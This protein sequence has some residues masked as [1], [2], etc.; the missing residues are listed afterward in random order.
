MS[1][2]IIPL[3]VVRVREPRTNLLMKNRYAILDGPQ[4]NSW[5]PVIST[6]Y[7]N[8][9]VQFSAPPPS[10]NIIVDRQV[11]V[12]MQLDIDIKG[13]DQGSKLVQIGVHD[14]LRA[15]PLSSVIDTLAVTI[16]NSSISI[17]MSDVISS[18]LRYHVSEKMREF[19]FSTAPSML[20]QYMAYSEGV[21]SVRNPLGT[22]DDSSSG[23][24]IPRGA[25]PGLDQKTDV[26]SNTEYKKSFIVTEPL[27]LSPFLFG[28]QEHRGFFGVQTLDFNFTMSGDLSRVWSHSS[29]G[30]ALDTIS[31]T[32]SN[33]K[34]LFNYLTPNALMPI[35][36]SIV[37]PYYTVQRY[38]TNLSGDVA[39]GDTFT[40]PSANIQLNSVPRRI[41]VY[42]R[43]T[44]SDQDYT[45]T[46]VFAG[47][48]SISLNWNNTSGLFSGATEE[49]LYRMSV[50]NGC[51]ISW[52]QWKNHVG[53]VLCIEMGKDIG[54]HSGV[55]APGSLG[56]Y[57]LQLTM[58]GVNLNS[59]EAI[60]YTLYVV[61]I[62]EGVF[63]IEENRSISEIG[64]VSKKD[65]MNSLAM[66]FVTYKS[67]M[68]PEGGS[69]WSGISDFFTESVPAAAKAVYSTAKDALP[70]IKEG[71]KVGKDVYDTVKPLMALAAGMPKR[72]RRGGV[73]VGGTGVGGRARRRSRKGSKK[74]SRK[75]GNLVGGRTISRALLKKR[76]R[77]GALDE[78]DEEEINYN[79]L[80]NLEISDN[81]EDLSG[82]NLVDDVVPFPE[83]PSVVSDDEIDNDTYVE[84]Y[85]DENGEIRT[86]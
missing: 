14:A 34:L 8:S 79:T 65:V 73:S 66:P 15:F 23:A 30:N 5:K 78:D 48:T 42:A 81:E 36:K 85:E 54:L 44:N 31:V 43:R 75:A 13:A 70:Y 16:N 35:P 55:E 58:N 4:Q 68:Q 28:G 19:D 11:K 62:S 17:N 12:Q 21:G 67:L 37:Y 60:P 64:V 74:G 49:D 1:N 29:S 83:I 51:N 3:E 25:F 33:P 38:P 41:Y 57:M 10:P 72:K 22:Y 40:I 59:L 69:W 63:V 2:S 61:T 24:D 53:S 77:G 9:S 18:L 20:D 84:Q 56:T 46:D 50:N 32:I 6:S 86:I 27:F 47:I 39:A 52:S 7:S 71:I 80:D 76:M 45:T 82:G 26:D